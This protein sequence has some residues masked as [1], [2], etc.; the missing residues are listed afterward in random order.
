MK[1]IYRS[2]VILFLLVIIY[3]L[4]SYAGPPSIPSSGGGGFVGNIVNSFTSGEGLVI[5]FRGHGKVIV[6]SRNRASYL[7]WLATALGRSNSNSN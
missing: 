4:V 5:K 7:Q 6:C 2:F 3:P 1:S